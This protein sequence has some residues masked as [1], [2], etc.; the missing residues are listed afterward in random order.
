[1]ALDDRLRRVLPLH[2]EPRTNGVFET[3]L[4]CS[5]V[6]DFTAMTERLGDSHALRVM[7]RHDR[8]I[9]RLVAAH[10]G[11]AV[12]LRGDGFLLALPSAV[13]ALACS[14]A[15]QRAFA[16]DR[17]RHPDEE[18]HVKIGIHAGCVLRDGDRYFGRNVVIAFRITGEAGG[19]EII[20]T[21]AVT[22]L[23]SQRSAVRFGEG[24]ELFLK[25]LLD[26]VRVFPIG[27]SQVGSR[28]ESDSQGGADAL[29]PEPR[30][31]STVG[32]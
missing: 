23:V 32:S 31:E 14:T 6:V 24:R 26:P 25:G 1:M 3:I 5:D 18:V 21:A 16:R 7:Q 22:E 12:E 20:A 28:P 15:I 11:S 8:I 4:V 27:W 17:A 19:G 10:G 13:S 30:I 9:R 2:I 29:E